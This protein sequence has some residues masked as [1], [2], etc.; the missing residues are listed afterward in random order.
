MQEGL[1]KGHPGLHFLNIAE[2]GSNE[3]RLSNALTKS[4]S[5]RMLGLETL[6][7]LL[8]FLQGFNED[9]ELAITRGRVILEGGIVV[10]RTS[11][12]RLRRTSQL[13]I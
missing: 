8:F 13:G 11:L 12:L 1:E 7:L 10:I 5:A 2:E 3:P 9:R 6:V 4:E